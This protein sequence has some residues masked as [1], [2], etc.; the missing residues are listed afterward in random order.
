[1]RYKFRLILDETW[2]FAVL[3]KNGRGLTE[4]Q[5]VD[6]N[7][8]DA[9]VGSLAGP[10][11]AAGGFCAGT[12]EVVEHQ[13]IMSTAY[14]FSAALPAMMST[15][16]S[17]TLKLLQ[18][19]PELLVQLREN[20][21]AMWAQLDPRSEW[22]VCNS[23]PLNPVMLLV[24]KT[25]VISVRALGIEDQE[26]LLQEC[27]DES[28]ANGVLIT[29]VKQMPVDQHAINN[30]GRKVEDWRA[31]PAIKVCLTVG[32]SRKEIEKA[33]TVIRHAITKVMSR[34]R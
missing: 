31:Q 12:E 4:A 10:L 26:R 7:S 1:M 13:R 11:C 17:E 5:N 30:G 25:D 16:A 24:L 19:E 23:S 9:L 21:T 29:R 28:L 8:V 14:V 6:P 22:V 33:G 2:S 18:D 34:K 27:V 3:G 15:A 20:I 32:L